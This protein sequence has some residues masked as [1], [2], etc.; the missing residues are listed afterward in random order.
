MAL[1]L[2]LF[3]S[4]HLHHHN[5][6]HHHHL[7][8]RNPISNHSVQ[9]ISTPVENRSGRRNSPLEEI[10]ELCESKT[11]IK[12]LNLIQ[13]NP[14]NSF[15]DPTQKALALGILLQAC[16]VDK[17]IE[18]GR[19]VHELIRE[20]IHLRNN[21]VLNTRVITMYAM[22]GSPSDSRS[23]FDQIRGK[24]L[25]QWNALLS[26]YTRNESYYDA[27]YLFDEMISITEYMP[28][29]FTF[30]C[31]IKACGGILDVDLGMAVHGMVVKMGLASDVFV[32]NALIA[33]YGRFGILENA[34]KMFEFMPEKNL[35]SWNSML[36]V[37]SENG[38]FQESFNFFRELLMGL[39][40]LVPDSA[41]MVTILP[42]C[43]GEGDSVMGKAVHGLVVKF[44]MSGDVMA[45][46][47]L[48]DMYSKCGLLE[49]ARVTFDLNDSKNVV[50]WNSMIGGYSR[51]GLIDG[52]F[53]LV[54]K[55]QMERDKFKANELTVLN[56]LPCC[57]AAS[58]L[59]Y[60]KEL[61]GYSIRQGFVNGELLANAFITAYARCALLSTAE[62][63]FDKLERKAVSSWNA[64]IGG[65]VQ[66]GNPSKALEKYLEMAHSG[67]DPDL[68]SI[69]SL[70][71]ACNHLKSLWYGKEIHGF[72]LRKGLEIDSFISTSLLSLYFSC[73]IPAHA[74]VLF[75]SMET[76]G[77]VSWNAMIAGYLHYRLPCA[78]LDIFREMV[79]DGI[80]PKEITIVGAL[81]AISRLS[82][83]HLGKE[84]HC[85]ALKVDLMKDSL[86]NCSL[87]DMYAKSGSIELSQ[88]VFD[89]VQ[90]KDTAL[91]TAMISG[92]A[93]H[94][95]GKEAHMLFQKLKKLGLKPNL[96]TF[97]N[98]LI[99]C[100]HA[101]MI[102]QGL[103]Y[104]TEMHAF[105]N[106]EPKLQHYACVIDMLGRAGRFVDAL[107]LIASMPIKPDARI[108]SSLLSSC[109]NHRELDLGNEFAEKLLELEPSRA[110][111]YILVS[112]FFAG[113]GKWDDVRR[114]RGIMKEM[115]LQKDVGCSWTEV[116]GKTYSFIVSDE[117]L[118]DSEE[119]R[120]MW[121][122]LE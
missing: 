62:C 1:V 81:G 63:L 95:Y 92:Y 119:I 24:N 42:A 65:C 50:S 55:M 31:V 16:G 110:E 86:V 56:V 34:D 12:A 90:D 35:V 101:G 33:M 13:E 32:G 28:D 40:G 107:E 89:Q 115:G 75:D 94:G 45:S 84:A 53:D 66:N 46:N 121:K 5:H 108:W 25:Y 68:V 117:M 93:I 112:N 36:S 71:L 80:Q 77:L 61:Q 91:C 18:I 100:N 109:R 43:A 83:L 49:E 7:P 118:P 69:G 9:S 57:Q 23:V 15:L 78:A 60:L 67:I 70:L 11:L 96:C 51:K 26:G 41:T 4:H 72:V 104:L 114:V 73:D 102:E 105:H 6:H 99:A 38:C 54:R 30:P 3:S 58:E 44:G 74:Q 64:L 97:S 85:F 111:S 2:P 39:D 76:R 59:L 8:I 120:L 106:I 88:T 116:G 103:S 98:I 113:F 87:I 47:A 122:T 19:K 27:L 48:I 52:T 29:N 21:P 37:L 20:S 82:A 17:N 22:C 14:H 79:S 10:T